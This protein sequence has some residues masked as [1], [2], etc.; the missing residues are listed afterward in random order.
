MEQLL[1]QLQL[2]KWSEKMSVVEIKEKEVKDK[3]NNSKKKKVVIDCYA[4]WCGPC[5]LLSP[6]LDELNNEIDTCEFYKINVDNAEEL[7][8][9]YGIMSIPT[10][11]IFENKELKEKMICFKSKEELNEILN[12]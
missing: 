3:I 8:R 2:K 7:S 1:Q 11:L 9:E 6:I 10:L 4:P 5:K 12:K